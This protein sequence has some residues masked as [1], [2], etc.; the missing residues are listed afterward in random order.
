MVYLEFFI[1]IFRNKR[2]ELT[3]LSFS[4]SRN[5]HFK[6]VS[7]LNELGQTQGQTAEDFKP[8]QENIFKTRFDRYETSHMPSHWK[9]GW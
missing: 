5:C 1:S 8:S 7:V 2:T 6:N 4:I 9:A 3:I